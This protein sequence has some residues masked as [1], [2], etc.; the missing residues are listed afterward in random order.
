MSTKIVT[1]EFETFIRSME[2]STCYV[3]IGH[4]K[5]VDVRRF[6]GYCQSADTIFEIIFGK[7]RC[8]PL[9]T[10]NLDSTT[11][12]KGSLEPI[13]VYHHIRGNTG[14]KLLMVQSTSYII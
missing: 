1:L 12:P 10:E 14:F 8:I 7:K 9:W 11:F 2:F 4:F 6:E 13:Y 5:G 3:V